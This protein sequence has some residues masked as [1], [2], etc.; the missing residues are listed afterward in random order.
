MQGLVVVTVSKNAEETKTIIIIV[1][2]LLWVRHH[3]KCYP[4]FHFNFIIDIL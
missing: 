1:E 2:R 4:L 3:D